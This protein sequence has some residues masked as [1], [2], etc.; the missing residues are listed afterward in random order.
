MTHYLGQSRFNHEQPLRA[1]VLLTNLGTP[2]APQRADLRRYLKQFLSDPRVVEYPRPLWWLILNL[3]VLNV[4]PARSA[5]AYRK[6]WTEQGSPL[7][8]NTRRLADG[9]IERVADRF[10]QPP[11][12]KIA[13]RYGQPS[14]PATLRQ[15]L[16]A[17]VNR[18]LVIPLYPQY[19]GSTTGSTFDAVSAELRRW[20]WVP[21]LRMV[22]GYH[23]HALYID[24]LAASVKRAWA[25]NRRSDLLLMSFHGIPKRYLLNG[26]PYHC[27]CHATARL[28]AEKLALG[29]DQWQVVFQSR[30][31]RE[32]WLQPYC[33]ETLKTLPAKGIKSVDVVC[34]GFS[35]DCLETLEEISMQNRELFEE[36]GGESLQYIPCLNDGPSHQDLIMALIEQHVSAWPELDQAASAGKLEERRMRALAMGARQ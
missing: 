21:E 32:P 28:L 7:L 6:I 11:L 12:V 13:M 3:I 30:F 25:E 35:A 16:D 33:D 8:A 2:E 15:M 18:L 29:D 14:I 24:A 1:A 23:D 34:P 22:N 31:G 10:T 4:R 20:R 26:D 5:Q 27:Q 17:Q 36:A 9:V 19:S